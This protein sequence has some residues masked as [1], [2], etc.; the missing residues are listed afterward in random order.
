MPATALKPS[1]APTRPQRDRYAEIVFRFFFG[2]LYREQIALGDPHPGN[3]LLRPDG[4]VGFLD[5]GLLGDIGDDRVEAERAIARAVRDKDAPALKAA[6]M[7][8]GYLP[9]RSRRRGA[10]PISHS[11]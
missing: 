5:F 3:Y 11:R 4:R 1:V 8:G 9:R 6:L 10:R 2:L 7:A